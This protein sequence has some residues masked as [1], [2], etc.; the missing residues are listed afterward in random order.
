MWPQ[1]SSCIVQSVH[2]VTDAGSQIETPGVCNNFRARACV[3]AF[4]DKRRNSFVYEGRG[5]GDGDF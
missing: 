2:N 4:F 3:P 5:E 1:S